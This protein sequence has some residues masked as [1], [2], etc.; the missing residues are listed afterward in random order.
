MPTLL[1]AVV[2]MALYLDG[3]TWRDLARVASTPWMAPDQPDAPI[4]ALLTLG[5]SLAAGAL[6]LLLAYVSQSRSG[7]EPTFS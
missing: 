6:G 4:A 7:R 5:P 1:A 2:A 3:G